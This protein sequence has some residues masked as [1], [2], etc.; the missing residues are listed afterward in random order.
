[1][2][3]IMKAGFLRLVGL[4]SN[5]EVRRLG[6][7]F[8]RL[9]GLVFSSEVRRLG[10]IRSTSTLCGSPCSGCKAF[11]FFF[12]FFFTRLMFMQ[13]GESFEEQAPKAAE[14]PC[15]FY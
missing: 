7:I 11:F 8:L 13:N 2:L 5:S 9:V 4:V 14:R 6:D 12:F 1:M 10:D 3:L 15:S